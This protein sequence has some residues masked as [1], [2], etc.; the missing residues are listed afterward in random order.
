M[1]IPATS[2]FPV[3]HDPNTSLNSTIPRKQTGRDPSPTYECRDLAALFAIK[4]ENNRYWKSGDYF[5]TMSDPQA[6]AE[7]LEAVDSRELA[8]RSNHIMVRPENFSDYLSAAFRAIE[9]AGE[10]GGSGVV[11]TRNHDL[12]F[13]LRVKKSGERKQYVIRLHD[14]NRN[15]HARTFVFD[16]PENFKPDF[17][18]YFANDDY[19]P[20]YFDDS[21]GAIV[22]SSANIPP[23][24]WDN[25]QAVSARDSGDA[26]QIL[27]AAAQFGLHQ[28]I[29]SFADRPI[30]VRRELLAFMDV[31][32]ASALQYAILNHNDDAFAAML[33]L[34]DGMTVNERFRFL[35]AHTATPISTA[36]A[37]HLVMQLGDAQAVLRFGSVLGEMTDSEARVLLNCTNSYGEPGLVR[38]M[39]QGNH[40]VIEA[41]G[42][43]IQNLPEHTRFELL[44]AQVDAPG[45][46]D[47][48]RPAWFSAVAMGHVQALQAWWKLVCRLPRPLAATVLQAED[49]AGNTAQVVAK[50]MGYPEIEQLLEQWSR[51]LSSNKRTNDDVLSESRKR[52]AL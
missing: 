37:L 44:S 38:P 10:D 13:S 1:K 22:V 33:H 49:A 51:D 18:K 30:D 7:A 35:S 39:W 46:P 11:H 21:P 45:E 41:F 48:R 36:P 2:Y 31:G 34:M 9:T 47:D 43:V 32:G 15:A 50:V 12:G 3:A 4:A 14:P 28:A 23:I 19:Y 25:A 6:A 29:R 20:A 52:P 17:R 5:T 40:A 27:S 8:R 26:N 42:A 16:R 24:D